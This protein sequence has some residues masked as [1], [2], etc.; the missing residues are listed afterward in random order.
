MVPNTSRAHGF[1]F[2]FTSS[3]PVNAAGTLGAMLSLHLLNNSQQ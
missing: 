3:P 1:H 2:P